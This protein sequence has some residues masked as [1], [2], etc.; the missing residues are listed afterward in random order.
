M[1]WNRNRLFHLGGTNNDQLTHLHFNFVLSGAALGFLASPTSLASGHHRIKIKPCPLLQGLGVGKETPIPPSS[2]PSAMLGQHFL[3][4]KTWSFRSFKSLCFS[5]CSPA[6]Q[7]TL[8]QLPAAAVKPQCHSRAKARA[9]HPAPC[10]T[11]SAWG[12]S[13]HSF[14][15]ED[16]IPPFR[17]PG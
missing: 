7:P 3:P 16:Q 8:G 9:L 15:E 14:L 5:W 6:L 17:P 13:Y 1:E 2:F 11:C 12:L 10:A 4:G